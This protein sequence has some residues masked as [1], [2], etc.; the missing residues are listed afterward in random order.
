MRNFQGIIFTWRRRW[1]VIFTVWKVSKYGVF[2]GPYFPAFGLNTERHGVSLHIQAK[3]EKIRTR[4]NTVFGHFSRRV[5][6]LHYC[7]SNW[8][9]PSQLEYFPRNIGRFLR[10]PILSN[11]CERLLL[12]NVPFW[13]LFKSLGKT[14]I[15]R[16][17][18]KVV[19]K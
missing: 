6:N 5:S 10:T 12:A 16:C 18:D 9:I 4:K 17:F 14:L 1:K 3:C 7:T 13:N 8:L 19:K 11:I 15:F 2:S